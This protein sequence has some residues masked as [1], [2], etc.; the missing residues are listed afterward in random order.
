MNPP[1]STLLERKPAGVR[2]VHSSLTVAAAVAEMNRHGIGC[3]IVL[4][5][6]RLAG[7]FTERDVLKRVVGGGLDPNKTLVAQVMT[8][9]PITISAETTVEEAMGIMTE[10]R[11]RH[12]P[13]VDAHRRVQ[14][15]ISIGDATRWTVDSHRAENEHLKNYIAGGLPA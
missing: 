14:G 7:V 1:V 13:I 3:I 10:K 5:G 4:D 12:L 11:C 8:P 9:N 6:E 2:S 15:I